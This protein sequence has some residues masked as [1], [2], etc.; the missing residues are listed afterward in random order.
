MHRL[1]G[2]INNSSLDDAILTP[3]ATARGRS[4]GRRESN[5]GWA[6]SV[7]CRRVGALVVLISST[8]SHRPLA[9]AVLVSIIV[10]SIAAEALWLRHRRNL[11]FP[12]NTT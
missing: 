8:A 12:S 2:H 7:S 10:V 1:C 4:I 11:N 5:L 3:G 6:T 9:L